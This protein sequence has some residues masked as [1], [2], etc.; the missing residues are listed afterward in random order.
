MRRA[1]YSAGR[2]EALVSYN[3]DLFGNGWIDPSWGSH[4]SPF[5]SLFPVGMLDD[6]GT[7][8][9][10]SWIGRG[11]ATSDGKFWTD[12]HGEMHL[13]GWYEGQVSSI[14]IDWNGVAHDL[15]KITLA[16]IGTML[17]PQGLLVSV[18][19]DYLSTSS[20]PQKD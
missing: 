6:S 7:R 8:Y 16:A 18:A 1:H 11:T 4:G 12:S 13:T 3:D 9:Y 20:P 2:M 19:Y 17:G 14:D 5:H 15:G 10:D